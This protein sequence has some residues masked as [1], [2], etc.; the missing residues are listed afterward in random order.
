MGFDLY[1][2]GYDFR[3]SI[4]GWYPLWR[5]VFKN[6]DITQ[7]EYNKGLSNDFNKISYETS[8]KIAKK[9]NEICEKKG[10]GYTLETDLK[11][12]KDF[13]IFCEKSK[14]FVIS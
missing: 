2:N 3:L 13:A 10:E 7:E 1:G 4:G 5:D 9:L 11:I 6:C 12:L 8:L 14:G